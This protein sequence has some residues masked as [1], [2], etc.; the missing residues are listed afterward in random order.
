MNA[1]SV[2]TGGGQEKSI[3]LSSQT[4]AWHLSSADSLLMPADAL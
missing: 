3:Q 2:A 4:E 1:G